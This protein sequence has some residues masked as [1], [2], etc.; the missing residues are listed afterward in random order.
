MADKKVDYKKVEVELSRVYPFGINKEGK[1]T[2]VSI[3]ELNGFDDEVI[4][5]QVEKDGKL[6]GY[7]QIS[8]SGGIDYN[9]ALMLANKD[10]SKILEAIQG[11]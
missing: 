8:V 1:N 7:V 6:A 10:S 9:E 5:K 2:V 3:N 4:S 11:F